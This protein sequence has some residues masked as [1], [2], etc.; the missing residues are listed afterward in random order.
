MFGLFN[1]GFGA[2]QLIHWGINVLVLLFSLSFHEFFHGFVADKMGDHTARN[3]GRLTL[4]P[5]AHLDWLGGTLIL[6]GAPVAWAKPVPVDPSQ[7]HRKYTV[8]GGMVRVAVAGPVS[9]LIL[10]FCTYLITRIVI[11]VVP[12]SAAVSPGMMVIFNFLQ[13]MY[14]VNLML[15]VF[16][17]LPVPPLDG[18]KVF[19]ALLP[20]RAYY[21]MMRYERY[22]G[23]AF[24]LLI[25]FRPAWISWVL[26]TV[27]Y[28]FDWLIS[29]PLDLLFGL[30]H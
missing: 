4:N 20:N 21:T 9:N 5:L 1:N 18:S 19:G 8:K 16:N 13:M 25:V 7:F 28:P 30:F 6:L 23:I 14:G 3:L 24:L 26:R 12:A 2:Q 10:A 17:I 27:A 29:T 15:A 22:I 11:L